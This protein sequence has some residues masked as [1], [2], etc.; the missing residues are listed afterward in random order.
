M[1]K[2]S[3]EISHCIS[4]ANFH[5]SSLVRENISDSKLIIQ[6]NRTLEE[7]TIE[8]GG[9][10]YRLER[11]ECIPNECMKKDLPGI[12]HRLWPNLVY[13]STVL[14]SSFAMHKNEIEGY[15]G[16]TD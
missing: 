14:G 10:T 3:E 9:F 4:T 5:D 2:Y 8:Y 16:K 7:M 1:E 12:L 15:C 13:A 6:L 11:A